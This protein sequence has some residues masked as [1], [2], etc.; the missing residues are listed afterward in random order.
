M[1]VCVCVENDEHRNVQKRA[2]N[3]YARW[4][5]S[6]QKQFKCFRHRLRCHIFTNT[7]EYEY[8]LICV[9]TSTRSSARTRA[10]IQ[11]QRKPRKNTRKWNIQF[12]HSL[13][14]S[15][16]LPSY[17]SKS[18]CKCDQMYALSA[19]HISMPILA[20]FVYVLFFFLLYLFLF[21]VMCVVCARC[22][23]DVVSWQFYFVFFFILQNFIFNKSRF[24]CVSQWV[25]SCYW[26]NRR[27]WINERQCEAGTCLYVLWLK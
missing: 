13:P 7:I 20:M 6:H 4:F 18:M 21:W 19:A 10:H 12:Q 2:E 26:S 17:C 14:F 24:L 15:D 25:C 1:C 27:K 3:S 9:G 16:C 5:L 8:E 11:Q 22:T 23:Y